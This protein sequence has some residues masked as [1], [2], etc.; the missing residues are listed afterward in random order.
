MAM[1]SPRAAVLALCL[2]VF[3]FTGHDAARRGEADALYH[4]MGAVAKLNKF[5]LPVYDASFDWSHDKRHSGAAYVLGMQ[6]LQWARGSA[7][8]WN[9]TC[10]AL[11]YAITPHY[12]RELPA[13]P[14]AACS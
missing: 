6:G 13:D 7:A 4:E 3:A 2:A 11:L 5:V 10:S 9:A 8:Q 14:I 12:S 1:V